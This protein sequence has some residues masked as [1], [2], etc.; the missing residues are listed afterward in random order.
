MAMSGYASK[1][2]ASERD[3]GPR[4][5][6]PQ[7]A[8]ES[9]TAA[10]RT[11]GQ[12]APRVPAWGILA[13]AGPALHLPTP[14]GAANVQRKVAP[15]PSAATN[16]DLI[17]QAARTG[18]TTPA[19]RLPYADQIQRLFG[20]HDLTHVQA[21]LGQA[22]TASAEAMQARA[23]AA[24]SHVVFAGA[25]DLHTAAHEA[26]HVVQQRSGVQLAGGIGQVGDSYEQHADAVAARVVAGQAAESLL[27]Q[28]A[29]ATS[30]GTGIQAVQR[31]IVLTDRGE[32]H[33]EEREADKP[34]SGQGALYW[35]GKYDGA[36]PIFTP[37]GP[38]DA[39]LIES[40]RDDD[41]LSNTLY[42]RELSR[43]V[44]RGDKVGTFRVEYATWQ[45]FT[46]N[47]DV[48]AKLN[49]LAKEGAAEGVL[50]TPLLADPTR[51]GGGFS[52]RFPDA[53]YGY[54]Y[55]KLSEEETIRQ[56]GP[57]PEGVTLLASVD[58]WFPAAASLAKYEEDRT[59]NF[60]YFRLH[61][62]SQ[63]RPRDPSSRFKTKTTVDTHDDNTALAALRGIDGDEVP[64]AADGH[65]TESIEHKGYARKKSRGAGQEAAMGGWNALAYAAYAKE[66][67]QINVD[68][69]QDWEWLHIRGSQN[70]GPTT[71]ANLVAGT[72]TTNS[73]MIPWED[74]INA[75]TYHAST[76]KPLK[77]KYEGTR[78]PGTNLGKE[79]KFTI[80]AP[81]GLGDIFEDPIDDNDPV[82]VTFDPIRGDV[83]D[84]MSRRLAQ[85]A[86]IPGRVKEVN[87][88]AEEEDVDD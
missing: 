8:A 79:I 21:H 26:A 3:H 25:P 11:A 84:K 80:S 73:R 5:N 16:S 18:V 66:V 47:A 46:D 19:T 27:D 15:A 63:L 6:L 40:G 71:A 30:G 42:Q 81:N 67:K 17:H 34:A 9:H 35:T 28:F 69:S 2:V 1:P 57:I 23:Y 37:V 77:I 12:V 59:E 87:A 39:V 74:K 13:A 56:L 70:G 51:K 41:D 52:N 58:G 49:G 88:E 38:V 43:M 72:S 4:T 78:Y 44:G 76:A 53:Q 85:R 10:D 61:L 86:A 31:Q 62:G 14:L 29:S 20:R 68:L 45:F 82:V 48:T 60:A 36:D 65:T 83:F 75:W 32:R 55:S 24:G 7:P 22:A 64:A 50:G 33:Y 54:L